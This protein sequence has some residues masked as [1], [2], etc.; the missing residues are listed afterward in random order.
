[1]PWFGEHLIT[2]VAAMKNDT[3]KKL[4]AMRLPAFADAYQKQINHEDEYNSMSFHACY[5]LM[6]NMI[7]GITT[8]SKD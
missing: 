5:W 3:L 8:I 6:R 4:K 7:P 2:E 1:M